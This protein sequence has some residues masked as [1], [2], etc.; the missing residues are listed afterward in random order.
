MFS[1]GFCWN[2]NFNGYISSNSTLLIH[3]TK[4]RS[5]DSFFPMY[6]YWI[7]SNCASAELLI[8]KE[9]SL[10][11]W[12]STWTNMNKLEHW[13][14]ADK[15]DCEDTFLPV[16]QSKIQNFFWSNVNR[17]IVPAQNSVSHK[18]T[19]VFQNQNRKWHV[20]DLIM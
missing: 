1:G 2:S 14:W 18:S 10:G 7:L 9:Y 5:I 17:E 19:L 15:T 6:K 12:L 20:Y 16:A 11:S 13:N 8:R 4:P 3:P